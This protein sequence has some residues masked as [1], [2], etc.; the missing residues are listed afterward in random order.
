MLVTFNDEMLNDLLLT[1][2]DEFEPYGMN[3][4]LIDDMI[5][6][7]TVELRFEMDSLSSQT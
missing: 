4:Q 3:Q 2:D 7:E 1:S 5:Y 6:E